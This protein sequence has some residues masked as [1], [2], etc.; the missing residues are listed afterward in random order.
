MLSKSRSSSTE[1]ASSASSLMLSERRNLKREAS[2]GDEPARRRGPGAAVRPADSFTK[3]C[4]SLWICK[5]AVILLQIHSIS[6]VSLIQGLLPSRL[7]RACVR[8]YRSSTYSSIR[9]PCETVH[10]G[11]YCQ[12]AYFCSQV[13]M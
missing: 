12:L 7:N 8:R 11:K 3:R 5:P 2:G 9:A 6:Q 10:S 1:L 4:S 13:V